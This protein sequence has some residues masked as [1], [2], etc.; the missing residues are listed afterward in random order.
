ML[1]VLEPDV[2]PEAAQ[3]LVKE[4]VQ[5][6]GR[7]VVADFARTL[8]NRV[9]CRLLPSDVMDAIL[10]LLRSNGT[11]DDLGQALLAV[12]GDA[13]NANPYVFAPLSKQARHP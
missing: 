13:A 1:A 11:D 8:C 2:T 5:R 9:M 6:I 3:K 10:E 7:G 12:A 4:I